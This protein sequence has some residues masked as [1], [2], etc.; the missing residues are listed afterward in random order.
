MVRIY[1]NNRCSKSRQTLELLQQQGHEVEIVDY[2]KNPPT[3]EEL[4]NVLAKLNLKP[5]QL[6][7][8]GE[9]LYKEQFSGK[10]LSDEEWIGIMVKNPILIERPIVVNGDRAAIGRPLENVLQ[11]L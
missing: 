10:N 5:T 6:L 1:H 8:T 11:I 2:L 3:S 4:K 9:Q 7:R